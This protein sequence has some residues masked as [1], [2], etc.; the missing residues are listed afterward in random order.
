[1]SVV[2]E[3]RY[4]YAVAIQT[5]IAELFEE[6]IIDAEELSEGENVKE[7][8]FALSAIVPC[9]ISNKL[10]NRDDNYLT[11]SHLINHLVFE[12]TQKKE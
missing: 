7:F 4:Q 2:K 6:R 9:Q 11:F 10:T 1:M 3:K 12:Y 5:K 8:L